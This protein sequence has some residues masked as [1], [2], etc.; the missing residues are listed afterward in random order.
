MV[1]GIRNG[2]WS[3]EDE[4]FHLFVQSYENGDCVL[5]ATLDARGYVAF[6]GRLREKYVAGGG[7]CGAT[8]LQSLPRAYGLVPWP[9][10]REDAH[11][12]VAG[13]SIM[14]PACGKMR[15]SVKGLAPQAYPLLLVEI[16]LLT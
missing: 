1:K 12:G 13:G 14:P 4:E 16:P 15:R 3:N 7:R 5:M 9:P 11:R 6:R 8:G 2:I 10:H